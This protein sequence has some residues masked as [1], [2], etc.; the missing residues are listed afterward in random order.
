MCISHPITRSYWIGVLGQYNLGIPFSLDRPPT[1]RITEV[2]IILMM[3]TLSISF[4]WWF[5]WELSFVIITLFGRI[6]WSLPNLFFLKRLCFFILFVTKNYR[7]SPKVL[8][9]NF[10]FIPHLTLLLSQAPSIIFFSLFTL[11]V[12]SLCLQYIIIGTR[13]NVWFPLLLVIEIW[14]GML[15]YKSVRV[16]WVK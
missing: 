3:T 15:A 4:S 6:S 8:R 12:L 10:Y 14:F 9:I 5:L 1:R 16:I 13:K 2:S 11:F 7:S